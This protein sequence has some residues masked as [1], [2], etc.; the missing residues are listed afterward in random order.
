M[1]RFVRIDRQSHAR[2]KP[3]LVL[4]QR[5]DALRRFAIIRRFFRYSM[6]VRNVLPRSLFSTTLNYQAR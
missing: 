4:L 1:V 3:I 2:P 5:G 6:M